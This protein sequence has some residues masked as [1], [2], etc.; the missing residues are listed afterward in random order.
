M[1]MK[2]NF[3]MSKQIGICESC[4]ENGTLKYRT[5]AIISCSLYIERVIMARVRY[6]VLKFTGNI[7][8]PSQSLTVIYSQ[9]NLIKIIIPVVKYPRCDHVFYGNEIQ[10]LS[11]I[12]DAESKQP[13]RGT[14]TKWHL[15]SSK[16][17]A[18]SS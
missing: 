8:L 11:R 6:M 12:E 14:K 4:K 9:L 10:E 5:R 1:E 17:M 16:D 13:Q 2:A 15:N 18:A 7:R 3:D